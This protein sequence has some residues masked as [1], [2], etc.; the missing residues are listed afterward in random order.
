GSKKH[1]DA[2]PRFRT[3]PLGSRRLSPTSLTKDSAKVPTAPSALSK[4]WAQAV[5]ESLR[6]EQ[7]DISTSDHAINNLA[8]PHTAFDSK[9]GSG[10]GLRGLS[11]SQEPKAALKPLPE[12]G[13]TGNWDEM[14]EDDIDFSADVVEFAD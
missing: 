1:E 13:G 8:S 9:R 12:F 2:L 10:E 11:Q 5:A 4:P 7:D 3:Q 6:S 14:T